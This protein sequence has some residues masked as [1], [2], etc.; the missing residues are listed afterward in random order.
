MKAGK[1]PKLV[2]VTDGLHWVLAEPHS[3]KTP[4]AIVDF[5]KNTESPAMLALDLARLLWRGRWERPL[6]P[7]PPPRGE[8]IPLTQF[9]VTPGSPPPQR[10]RFPDGAEVELSLWKQLLAATAEWLMGRGILTPARTPVLTSPNYALVHTEPVH[11]DGR[12]MRSIVQ[13]SNGLYL[14]V[15]ASAPQT[16]ARARKLLQHCGS[17][18]AT[19]LLLPR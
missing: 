7:S 9:V 15:H 18:P 16:V 14:D 4:K 6:P 12:P 17:D 11:P 5:T 13:L 2:G 8:W 1:E 3:L 10:I 19:V